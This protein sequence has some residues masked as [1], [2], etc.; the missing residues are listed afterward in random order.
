MTSLHLLQTQDAATERSKYL[1]SRT[2]PLTSELSEANRLGTLRRITVGTLSK[3]VNIRGPGLSQ[4]HKQRT[5][6]EGSSLHTET[7]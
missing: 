2:F 5:C 7:K 1:V 3:F 4:K 6:K